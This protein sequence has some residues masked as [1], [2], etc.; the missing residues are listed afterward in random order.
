MIGIFL[1]IEAN[2]LDPY[3]HVPLEIAIRFIDLKSKKNLATLSSKIRPSN[4]QWQK[5]DPVSLNVNGM[6]Y[7]E[8]KE[9][10]TISNVS[11]KITEQFK[12]LDI[13]RTRAVFICQNP[14][15][16][17]AFF[18]QIISATDQ[19]ARKWPY[20]WLDLA[21][22]FWALQSSKIVKDPNTAYPWEIGISKNKIAKFLK[23]DE[24]QEPH[25]ALQGVDHLVECY[26]ALQQY[27]AD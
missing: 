5:S 27:F 17:R 11:Q 20:H 25:K 10:P 26:F 2:G 14:S 21:S 15:F 8:L 9:A 19:E 18:S 1:D 3:T 13:K 23:L 7:E 22:M 12:A 16:D 4:E 6:K 24:E